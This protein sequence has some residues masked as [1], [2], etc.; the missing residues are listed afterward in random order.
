M[1]AST[2]ARQRARA[3]DRGRAGRAG[4]SAAE[5]DRRRAAAGVRRAP[6]NGRPAI[7]RAR[8]EAAVREL[9]IALGEDPD[10]EGLRETPARVARAYEEIF[11]G[12]YEPTRT[13]CWTRRSTS[14]T[15][16]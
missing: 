16:S 11:A 13:P 14:T 3:T 4:W 5:R 7:D 6:H 12:L 9:L 15:R 1:T 8:A 10:R 2:P